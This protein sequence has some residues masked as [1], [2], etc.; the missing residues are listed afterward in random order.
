MFGWKR[1][2]RTWPSFHNISN[3]NLVFGAFRNASF[4]IQ[5]DNGKCVKTQLCD[6][7]CLFAFHFVVTGL[8]DPKPNTDK[9]NQLDIHNP[10]ISDQTRKSH[11]KH[12]HDMLI[13][14]CTVNQ[15]ND[16]FG[17]Q[18]SSVRGCTLYLLSLIRGEMICLCWNSGPF[19]WLVKA[20]RDHRWNFYRSLFHI[21]ILFSDNS[22]HSKHIFCTETM[23]IVILNRER[24]TC[25]NTLVTCI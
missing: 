24:R 22:Y 4:I 9:I 16:N 20:E 17:K 11:D 7:L 10:H 19:I 13:I 23:L 14:F 25:Y 2:I 5:Y 6:L 18:C 12:Q 1:W 3:I 8:M 21:W 15:R